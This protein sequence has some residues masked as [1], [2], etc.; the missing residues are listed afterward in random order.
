MAKMKGKELQLTAGGVTIAY[1]TSCSL[2]TTTQVVD[3]RTKDDAVGPAGDVD[4]IDWNA[5]SEN[6][7]GANEDETPEE[8]YQ[9][10]L[11]KQLAGEKI[12]VAMKLMANANGA[13]P[14]T[15]WQPNTTPNKAFAPYG[16]LA[17]I[18][19]VNLNAPA[20]GNATVSTNFKG[21]GPLTKLTEATSTATE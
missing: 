13:I 17:I 4:Y 7:V 5:S 3:S 6:I 11:D 9:S 1:A 12:Q 16:G 15:G 18:E 21:V 2:N 14:S 20:D 19:S 8:V 10:L